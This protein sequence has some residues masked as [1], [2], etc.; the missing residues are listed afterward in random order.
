MTSAI[1]DSLLLVLAVTTFN[2]VLWYVLQSVRRRSQ[3]LFP[4][5]ELLEDPE[6]RD[7][8]WNQAADLR[9]HVGRNLVLGAAVVGAAV[10]AFLPLKPYVDRSFAQGRVWLGRAILC[11][12]LLIAVAT[13][14]GLR[15]W[16]FPRGIGRRLRRALRGRGLPVC[17]A[18]GYNLTAVSEPRCPE[19]GEPFDLSAC[20][21]CAGRGYQSRGWYARA[22]LC[23]AVLAAAAAALWLTAGRRGSVVAAHLG[24]P[25]AI[26]GIV[27]GLVSSAFLV[28]YVLRGRRRICA[29]CQGRGR[30][31]AKKIY[32]RSTQG[33]E[34]RK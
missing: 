11:S 32:V 28:S 15:A 26:L 2:A 4:E 9:P 31:G 6:E 24:R 23:C 16:L 27:A 13:Y 22:A 21:A 8:A 20:P 1:A 12:L 7:R 30:T 5:L 19:C 25:A 3:R 18:C 10:L 29:A 17:L 14:V 34:L 33:W